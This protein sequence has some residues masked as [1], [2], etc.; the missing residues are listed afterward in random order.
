MPAI[1]SSR[2]GIVQAL[3]EP[4]GIPF[5]L[6]GWGGFEGTKAIITEVGVSGQGN[7]QFLHSL[8]DFIFVY[9]FGERIGTV[10]IS[11]IAFAERC[12]GGGGATGIENVFAYYNQ[13]RIAA[14]GRPLSIQ[15]GNSGNGRFEGFLTTVQGKIDDAEWLMGHF[16][17]GFH[18][19]PR[20][21]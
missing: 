14:T 6:Q 3:E 2:P 20:T 15:I 8:K 13:N 5:R 4:S 18:T 19:F 12:P 7:Y 9:V 1:I 17:L 10:Q 16:S 11:G 21:G